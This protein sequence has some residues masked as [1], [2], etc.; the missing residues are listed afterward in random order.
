M[1]EAEES[2]GLPRRRSR[3][4]GDDSNL[5]HYADSMAA[6]YAMLADIPSAY[7]KEQQ[8]PR[9][10]L[11]H[12]RFGLARFAISRNLA[13]GRA[14]RDRNSVRRRVAPPRSYQ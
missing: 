5:A 12:G 3:R 7:L 4:R 9:G 13:V 11:P 6:F 1:P 10:G 2:A 8:D 14:S